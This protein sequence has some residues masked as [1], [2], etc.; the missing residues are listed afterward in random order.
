MRELLIVGVDPGTTTGYAVLGTSGK[1]LRMRSSKQLDLNNVVEEIVQLGSILAIGTDRQKCPQLIE[2]I[3]AK[4]GAKVILPGYDLPVAEKESMVQGF[5]GNQH[6]KDSLAAALYAYKE[7]EPLLQR[8]EK[9]LASEGKQEL[10]REVTRIVVIDGINIK[11][12]LRQV[13]QQMAEK[14]PAAKAKEGATEQKETD[15]KEARA[16]RR[17]GILERENRI[18]RGYVGKLL[19]RIRNVEKESRKIAK[20][21]RQDSSAALQRKSDDKEKNHSELLI[22]LQRILNEKDRRIGRLNAEMR[23]LETIMA[24][25]GIVAKKLNTLGFEE[26]QQKNSF[27]KIGENDLVLVENPDS[28]SEKT[29]YYLRSKNVTVLTREKITAAVARILNEAELTAIPAEGIIISEAGNFAAADRERLEQARK[30]LG[31]RNLFGMIESYKEERR[32]QLQ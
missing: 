8:I 29:L 15:A 24:A 21:A 12:A 32:I 31:S 25:G 17:L 26:L 23:Q 14:L 11:E 28:F 4:T 1:L 9:A 6:Q 10:F 19:G 30:K 7:L 3:A 5:A 16:D 13:E 27:L 18:L 22:K 20:S 2:K